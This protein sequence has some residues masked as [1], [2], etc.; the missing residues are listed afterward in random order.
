MSA[1]RLVRLGI[2]VRREQAELA[3]AALLPVLQD[4]AEETA[5]DAG[6]V[7]YALYAPRGELPADEEI[8]ALA[9]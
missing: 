7:E 3:L 4:G 6:T 1:S 9:G 2:R 5:P 8:R